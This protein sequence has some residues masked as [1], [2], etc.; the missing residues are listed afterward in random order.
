MDLFP[1]IRQAEIMDWR[2]AER[3]RIT[4]YLDDHFPTLAHD[5]GTKVD[6]MGWTDWLWRSDFHDREVA[7]LVE[8]W[9]THSF[10]TLRQDMT[11]TVQ[12][13]DAVLA[14]Q[15]ERSD[16]SWREV[17]EIGAT[18]AASAAPFAILPFTGSIAT[19]NG[20]SFF[21]FSTAVVSIP[22]LTGVIGA[23]ILGGIASTE[24]R[25]RQMAAMRERYKTEVIEEARRRIVG[26][27]D[28]A[29][30]SLKRV[31]LDEVDRIARTRLEAFA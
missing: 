2:D 9:N 23:A 26:A 22:I 31:L 21:V 20:T 4:R 25:N 24:F 3:V 12:T 27:E 10:D 28:E 30:S 18:A 17:A 16:L 19:V 1:E 7:P 29:D 13:L 14:G 6:E 8:A 11:E 15:S 5:I